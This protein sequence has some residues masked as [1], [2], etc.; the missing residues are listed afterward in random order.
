MKFKEWLANEVRYKGMWRMF[1]AQHPNMDK[2][3]GKEIYNNRIGSALD[4]VMSA[5]DTDPNSQASKKLT[6]RR[7]QQIMTNFGHLVTDPRNAPGEIM[8]RGGFQRFHWGTPMIP[9]GKD[10]QPGVTPADFTMRVQ[11]FFLDRRF[12]SRAESEIHDDG[13]R[14]AQQRHTA[15]STPPE[16]CKP[17]I[18][19]H[20]PEGL[21]LLEGWHRVMAYFWNNMPPD[22]KAIND[23]MDLTDN[24]VWE[25]Y[26]FSTWPKLPIRAYVGTDMDTNKPSL[27]GHFGNS[28]T[29]ETSPA[30]MADTGYFPGA[31]VA[32][33]SSSVP[34]AILPFVPAA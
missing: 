3:V 18:M 9:R 33:G 29:P 4:M 20:T 31:S 32:A 24:E 28:E 17:V 10:G 19:R 1:K 6:P 21:D 8:R 7:R 15:S 2:T 13:N 27:M 14:T 30:H 12:G 25:Q 23:N 5:R 16:Q 11:Q 26:R 34:P 22:I